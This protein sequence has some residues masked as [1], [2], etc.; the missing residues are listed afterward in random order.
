VTK[1]YTR[2]TGQ[3]GQDKKEK[4]HVPEKQNVFFQKVSL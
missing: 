3:N 1:E 4:K 2:L